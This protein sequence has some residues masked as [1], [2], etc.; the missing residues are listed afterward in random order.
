L[1]AARPGAV[2]IDH[3]TTSAQL[4]RE[5][6]DAA[7]TRGV[8][9]LDA[10]VSGGETGAKQGS[11]TVMVGGDPDVYARACPVLQSY[12]RAVNLMGQ[13]GAGQL[14][15]MVNQICVVALMQGLAEGIAFGERAGLD[16]RRV[17]EDLSKGAAT[18]WQMEHRGP[19][20][21]G[22][23]FDFG[24]AID[25]MHKDL[26]ICLTEAMRIGAL[27]PHTALIERHYDE[28]RAQGMGRQDFSALIERLRNKPPAP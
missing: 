1:V 15:K 20:M 12:G 19:T 13:T 3:S 24:F 23:Q 5:L 17:L 11:L 25:W 21:I 6:A 9:F 7:S 26:N 14:T 4:A 16:M 8:H 2:L 18:S 22:R 28:L 27:L 10:P